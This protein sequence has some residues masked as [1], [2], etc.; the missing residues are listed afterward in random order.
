MM[1]QQRNKTEKQPQT[2]TEN[3]RRTTLPA[4]TNHLYSEVLLALALNKPP[5]SCMQALPQS[6]A[7]L[8]PH[9]DIMNPKPVVT[10]GLAVRSR[11]A[12][13]QDGARGDDFGERGVE[14]ADLSW[15]LGLGFRFRV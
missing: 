4:R 8:K 5:P 1:A 6:S 10:K 13:P 11:Q 12:I 3:K 7:P 9:L 14:L 2:E 15:R